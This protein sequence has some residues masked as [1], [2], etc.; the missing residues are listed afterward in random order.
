[1]VAIIYLTNWYNK[2][3]IQ[4]DW[5]SRAPHSSNKFN[6][7]HSSVLR[8]VWDHQDPGAASCGHRICTFSSHVCSQCRGS[9]KYLWSPIMLGYLP[10]FHSLLKFRKFLND[11]KTIWSLSFSLYVFSIN[12]TF[13]NRFVCF[14]IWKILSDWSHKKLIRNAVRNVFEGSLLSDPLRV[15]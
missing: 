8:V 5:I 1:M 2:K 9:S 12:P 6:A 13:M 11:L 3:S 7:D 15:L 14:F 4:F 10:T